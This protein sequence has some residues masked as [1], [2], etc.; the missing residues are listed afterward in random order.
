MRTYRIVR[1]LLIGLVA[2][3]AGVFS[4]ADAA[5]VS[6]GANQPD[7]EDGV[8]N[9]NFSM[10]QY[11]NTELQYVA[12]DYIGNR[13][14][15]LM[16]GQTFRTGAY[17]L[18]Y[19]LSSISVRQVNWGP[20]S[21]DYTGGNITIRVFALAGGSGPVWEA[22]ELS[23]E[24]GAVGG[25]PGGVVVSNM[26]SAAQW[27]TVTL[28]SP[29]NLNPDTLYGF[30][31]SSDGTEANEGFFMEMD[32]TATDYY[33]DGFAFSVDTTS[34]LWDG[35]NGQ[36]SDRAFVAAMT[37]LAEADP[38][39]PITVSPA[40]G[41]TSITNPVTVEA[42]VINRGTTFSN[43][44]MYL[45]GTLVDASVA[46]DGATNTISYTTRFPGATTHTGAVFV[47][48]VDSSVISNVWTF[49]LGGDPGFGIYV[50]GSTQPVPD[51]DDIYQFDFANV[52]GTNNVEGGYAN[53]TYIRDG[54][55]VQGQT[56]T[57]GSES[58]RYELTAIW[59]KHVEG[60]ETYY[61]FDDGYTDRLRITDPSQSG[62]TGFVIETQELMV[63]TNSGS[64]M[65]LR[66]FTLGTGDWIEYR[67]QTPIVLEGNRQYGFDVA[68]GPISEENEVYELA[69]TILNEYAGGT[70][71]SS[72]VDGIDDVGNDLGDNIL[73]ARSGDRAFMIELAPSTGGGPTVVPNIVSFA[74]SGGTA[75][76]TWDSETG[77]TYTIL[78]ASG[79]DDST[80]TEVTNGIPGAGARTGVSVP[81]VLDQ[82]FFKVQGN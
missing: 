17:A 80:W 44:V 58:A 50:H 32:G 25:D 12:S 82:E 73:T 33:E 62:T 1:S 30:A 78:N 77:V 69:G 8:Q 13:T 19:S 28:G 46:T 5:V 26:P 4:E 79:L 45:D 51:A 81:A 40:D 66:A 31:I 64:A 27:L 55:A 65:N 67:L 37:Q 10:D 3:S 63:Q 47:T 21:W 61:I 29:L 6:L 48:G 2:V 54:G 23:S 60:Y 59:L 35:G 36:P 16:M 52:S 70:A 72:G 22:T 57:T 18:G 71:Y 11:D 15:G 74:V 42:V 39:F 41:A 53:A 20:T 9:L 68:P 14:D 76:L 75:S 49:T 7:V 24:T 56:F 43:A 38:F 34:S